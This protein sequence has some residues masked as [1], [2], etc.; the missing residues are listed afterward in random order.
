[1]SQRERRRRRL[2]Q[3]CERDP[4]PLLYPCVPLD[5]ARRQLPPDVLALMT[6]A[7]CTCCN[8]AVLAHSP[9]HRSMRDLARRLGIALAILC[10]PCGEEMTRGSAYTELRFIDP[11]LARR[12]DRWD[13]MRN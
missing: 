2:R 3:L 7:V 1:M 10:Q 13:S 8:T 12:M 4:S 5:F 6:E 11:G 9:V